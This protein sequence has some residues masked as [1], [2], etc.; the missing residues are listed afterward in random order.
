MIKLIGLKHCQLASELF[1]RVT[2]INR[3]RQKI[4]NW[5]NTFNRQLIVTIHILAEHDGGF[6]QVQNLT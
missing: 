2:Q 5:E 4:S 1:K 6:R 3:V